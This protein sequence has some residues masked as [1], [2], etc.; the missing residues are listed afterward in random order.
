MA[1]PAAILEKH[2]PLSDDDWK[3]VHRHTL[4]GA[5]ILHAAPDLSSIA[6]TVRSS[7]ERYDGKGYPDSLAGDEIPLASRI[8][9]VCDAFDAMMSDRPYGSAMG[10]AAA[11]AELQ[12]NAGTQFDPEVVRAFKVVFEELGARPEPLPM[13]PTLRLVEQLSA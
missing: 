13:L 4:I 11:L 6:D 2:G 1:I 9:F 7:H 8:V 10:S 12:R 3:F 5:R